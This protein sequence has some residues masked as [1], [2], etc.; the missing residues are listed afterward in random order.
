MKS[1]RRTDGGKS[2]GERREEELKNR[3]ENRDIGLRGL[4]KEILKKGE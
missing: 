4:L 1:H 3:E 2:I